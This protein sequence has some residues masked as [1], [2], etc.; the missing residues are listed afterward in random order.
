MPIVL[1]NTHVDSIYTNSQSNDNAFIVDT[2]AG[3]QG[4]HRNSSMVGNPVPKG[5]ANSVGATSTTA[6]VQVIN[7]YFALS[8][9]A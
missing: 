9:P 2:S 3:Y 5:T 4:V 6:G 1:P 8:N 7:T